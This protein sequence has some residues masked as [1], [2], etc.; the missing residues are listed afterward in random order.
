V[1]VGEKV[2]KKERVSLRKN[3]KEGMRE[4][5]KKERIGQERVRKTTKRKEE[6][7]W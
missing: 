4:E 5:E 3:Q 1:L 6:I 7:K 2:V